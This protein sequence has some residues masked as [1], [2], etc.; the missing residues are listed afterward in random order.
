VPQTDLPDAYLR[1]KG[2]QSFLGVPLMVTG[3]VI[4]VLHVG[5][6]RFRH[7]LPA[8]IQFLQVVADRIALAIEHARLVESARAVRIEAEVAERMLQVQD[9]FLAVAAHELKTPLTSTKLASQILR[10]TFDQLPP[11]MQ[12]QRQVVETIDQ[13]VEKLSQLVTQLL[14]MAR[15]QAGHFRLAP[16]VVDVPALV[17]RVVDLMQQRTPPH[18]I[19]I[20]TA[21]PCA[22]L[23]D[24]LRLEQVLTNLLDN[25]IKFAPA[26]T[27]IE[28]TLTQPAADTLQLAVRDYGPGVPLELRQHLF[29]RYFQVHTESH[30]AG[31]GLGLYISKEIV[32][33]HGGQIDAEFPDDGGTR[34]VITLPTRPPAAAEPRAE[35]TG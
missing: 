31:L 34:F 23:M 5:T 26:N 25:A 15:L 29:E 18:Q 24:A 9:Q 12:R 4:G 16:E 19:V 11:E 13:Q 27:R 20:L 17:Q 8:D 35:Q 14:E 1:D 10:R 22:A 7:F 30:Q 3:R 28:I 21:D 2:M 6:V 32:G 33:Q